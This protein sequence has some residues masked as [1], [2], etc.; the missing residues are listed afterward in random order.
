MAKALHVDGLAE[1]RKAFLAADKTLREDLDDALQEAAAPVRSTAQRLAQ[2]E[3][4]HMKEGS[5]WAL[6]RIGIERRN[7]FV[8]VAPVERGVKVRGRE[9]F[10][11]PEFAGLM[12]DKAMEP[13]LDAHRGEI[14]HRLDGLLG[15]VKRVWERYG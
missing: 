9:R 6:M 1:L 4:S 10:R 12:R 2:T 15:E 11:R 14:V 3:I 7:S 13:A 8:Y 5:S